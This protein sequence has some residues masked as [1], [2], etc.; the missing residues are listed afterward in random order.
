MLPPVLEVFVIW[1]PLDIEGEQIAR[2]FVDHFRGVS[3]SGIIGGGIHVAA[4][5]KGWDCD[6]GCPQPCYSVETSGPNGLASAEFVAFVPLLG[7][8]MAWA[9]QEDGSSWNEF[10]VGLVESQKKKPKQIATFP[11]ALNKS[12][13]DQTKLGEVFGSFQQI[14]AS[15]KLADGD[16]EV[17]LRCRDLSQGLAQFL[18]DEDDAR[19]T[20]FLSHTKRS[21]LS[22]GKDVDELVDGVRKFIAATRLDEFFDAHDLQ[23]GKDWEAELIKNAKNSAL[24]AV[25]TDLYASRAW[26]QKEVAVAKVTGMPVVTLD[27][28]GLGEERGSFLMDH[29]PRIPTHKDEG[30]WQQTDISRALNLLTDECLKREIWR[31]QKRVAEEG[32]ALAVDWWSS[33]APEPLTLLA[34]IEHV[35]DNGDKIPNSR[36]VRILH[37]D[38]PLGRD[39]LGVLKSMAKSSKLDFE[40]DVM[41]PRLLAM[42]GG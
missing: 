18:A 1:H 27:A 29:V 30:H 24:L 16:T 26:C 6:G 5:S 2:E 34:W 28:L 4:R 37:P 15:P 10:V 7:R 21:N 42:R 40:I 32:A 38:P 39:E 12:A 22:E 11:F 19:L 23:P 9:V 17:G 25:R 20:V 3:F 35:L 13:T 8:H 41:T 33:H 31:V 36:P 14:G